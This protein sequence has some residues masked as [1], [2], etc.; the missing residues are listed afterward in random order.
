LY[1]LAT[2]DGIKKQF[3]VWKKYY[4]KFL[5]AD[6]NA[7]ILDIGC[8]NGGFVYFLQT[9]KF[10][11]AEG[12]D[13]SREQI[14][15]AHKLGIKNVIQADIKEFLPGH[16]EMYDLIL[17]RDIIEHLTKDEILDVLETIYKSL[18]VD[19]LFIV[20]SP[21]GESPFSGRIRYGDFTHEV[22]FTRSSLSQVLTEVG[23]RDV[24]FYSAGPVP[25]GLKSTARYILW[26][27]IESVLRLYT[28]IETGSFSGI[29]TQ[30]VIAAAR[31]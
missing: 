1:G 9:L 16:V 12:I 29:F 20:Q 15:S 13:I 19:G 24:E 5:P 30:N 31:K 28:A 18:K 10:K 25:K 22:V 7:K 17:A 6:G 2:V 27:C 14:A 8:G 21:N 26:K 3:P 23:F 4:A 11:N